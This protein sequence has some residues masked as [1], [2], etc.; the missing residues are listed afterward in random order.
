M[1]STDGPAGGPLPVSGGATATAATLTIVPGIALPSVVREPDRVAGVDR[2]RKVWVDSELDDLVDR[3]EVEH[4]PARQGRATDRHVRGGNADSS[5]KDDRVAEP[6]D[7]GRRDVP[8]GLPALDRQGRGVIERSVG[9][10]CRRSA[11]TEGDEVRLELSDIRPGVAFAQGSISGNRPDQEHGGLAIDARTG[12]RRAPR[13]SRA[14]AG[15]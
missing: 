9:P 14:P 13:S 11:R 10:Q 7:P 5:R 12:S 6:K 15:W 2:W 3:R 1:T 8:D 4:R